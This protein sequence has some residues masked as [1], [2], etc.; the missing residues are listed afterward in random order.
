MKSLNVE[1]YRK[2]YLIRRAEEKIQEHYLEDEMKT[3]MHMSMGGEAI[4]AGVCGALKSEDQILGTYRSHGIYL[5]K[6]ME[7]DNFFAEMYGKVTGTSKG[8][9]GSMHLMA[10]EAGLICT[11]AIVGSHIPVSIG[12]AFA[13]KFTGNKK[14]VAVFFG[15]GAIDEGVFWES[16]N[17]ACLK[18]LPVIFVCEDNGLAIHT[19]A[20]ERH[21]YNSITDIVCKFD[22]NVFESDSTDVEVIY[23]LTKEALKMMQ[24]NGSPCFLYLKYYRY[25]E[26]V[27]VFDDFN[28]DYRSKV[29]FDEWFKRDPVHRQ[30]KKLLQTLSENEIL[31]L[32]KAIDK[33]IANSLLFA[34]KSPFPEYTLAYEDVYA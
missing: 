13:N 21:G 29:E 11:S 18:K 17:F 31:D 15:D 14:I 8:K 22:C 27:G 12:A 1:L 10:P 20:N 2:M 33:Q 9:A 16:L 6:T 26:H 24:K 30:R 23:K 19:P 3:P 28:S 4:V 34:K 25:L 5:A 32:E 7:T